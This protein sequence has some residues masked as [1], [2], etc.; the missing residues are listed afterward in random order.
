[1]AADSGVYTS[2]NSATIFAPIVFANSTKSTEAA[3]EIG[4]SST[5]AEISRT[6]SN[7]LG[8]NDESRNLAAG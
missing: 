5:F 8:S 7:M 6:V 1:M 3:D 2:D 4:A